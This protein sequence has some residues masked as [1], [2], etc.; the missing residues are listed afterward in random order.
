MTT[1]PRPPADAHAT[2]QMLAASAHAGGVR[3]QRATAKDQATII[4]AGGS[5]ITG[6]VFCRPVRPA[7]RR[8]AGPSA[9]L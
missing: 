7:S 9:G 4:Q 6:N 5:V 3:E 1:S 8:L 2:E